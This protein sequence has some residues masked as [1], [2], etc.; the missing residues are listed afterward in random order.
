[1]CIFGLSQL[2]LDFDIEKEQDLKNMDKTELLKV[3]VFLP[4]ILYKV[5]KSHD[6]IWKIEHIGLTGKILEVFR[7]LGMC[8]RGW[9]W[10]DLMWVQGKRGCHFL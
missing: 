4:T 6:F 7:I 10:V 9:G 5:V 3:L 8:W 1:M 2:I